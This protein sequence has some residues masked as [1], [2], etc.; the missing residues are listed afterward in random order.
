VAT[1][2]KKKIGAVLRL[3][4]GDDIIRAGMADIKS[5]IGKGLGCM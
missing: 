2:K 1:H 4:S 5:A 3:D